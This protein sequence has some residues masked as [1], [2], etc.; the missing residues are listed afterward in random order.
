MNLFRTKANTRTN[1][2]DNKTK[3]AEAEKKRLKRLDRLAL[4]VSA[5]LVLILAGII[6]CHFEGLVFKSIL[7]LL[8]MVLLGPECI[9]LIVTFLGALMGASGGAREKTEKDVNIKK[10][11]AVVICLVVAIVILGIVVVFEDS[12]NVSAAKTSAPSSET[13]LVNGNT[14]KRI[15]AAAT[16][17]ERTIH[18]H[19][20]PYQANSSTPIKLE[21]ILPP[22]IALF[23]DDL[24]K[25][26]VDKTAL[27]NV[28]ESNPEIMNRMASEVWGIVTNALSKKNRRGGYL[29][30]HNA[31]EQG[32]V[33]PEIA[34]KESQ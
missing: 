15:T 3:L 24:E 4:V 21:V 11:F 23:E 25:H 30:Q 8:L 34:K 7:F 19:G 31:T 12:S 29:G 33:L 17:L 1:E 10:S 6:L 26:G 28:V 32:D 18:E 20:M 9:G 2:A 16:E 5:F 13:E 27:T 22:V 14:R